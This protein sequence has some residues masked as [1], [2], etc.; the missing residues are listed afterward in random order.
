MA[1]PRG[2]LAEKMSPVMEQGVLVQDGDRA[3]ADDPSQGTGALPCSWLLHFTTTQ[4]GTDPVLTSDL[5]S[6]AD[7]VHEG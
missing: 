2:T 7:S 3:Q 6:G 5:L 4:M 1:T